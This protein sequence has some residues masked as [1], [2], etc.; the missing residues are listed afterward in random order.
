MLCCRSFGGITGPITDGLGGTAGN[1]FGGGRSGLL[2]LRGGRSGAGAD[3]DGLLGEVDR[4]V[5][6]AGVGGSEVDADLSGS[7]GRRVGEVEGTR[8]GGRDVVDGLRDGDAAKGLLGRWPGV[9]GLVC[10]GGEV[11]GGSGEADNGG[12]GSWGWIN[13]SPRSSSLPGSTCAC[14]RRRIAT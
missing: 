12:E 8:G 13:A 10:G 6:R 2:G 3:V 14:A 4:A 9:N 11:E 7:G 1:L 5:G